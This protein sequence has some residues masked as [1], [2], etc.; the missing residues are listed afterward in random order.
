MQIVVFLFFSFKSIVISLGWIPQERLLGQHWLL[1][2]WPKTTFQKDHLWQPAM[3]VCCGVSFSWL[4]YVKSGT[5]NLF[6]VAIFFWHACILNPMWQASG[7]PHL[8][9]GSDEKDHPDD[10]HRGSW[11]VVTIRA[12]IYRRAHHVLRKGIGLYLILIKF[13]WGRYDSIP[14]NKWRNQGSEVT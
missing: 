10:N 11:T 2:L 5:S 6:E 3:Y 8:G 4:L 12:H 7:L 9:G 13:P 1:W 14:F